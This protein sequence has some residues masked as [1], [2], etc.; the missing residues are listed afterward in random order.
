MPH[1]RAPRSRV[2]EREYARRERGTAPAREHSLVRAKLDEPR[3]HAAQ[4][5]Q[6]V[7][8]DVLAVLEQTG[9]AE[10]HATAVVKVDQIL[11]HPLGQHGR[12]LARVEVFCHVEGGRGGVQ[13]RVVAGG[14][15][16]GHL[17]HRRG[18]LHQRR[19]E[20][21]L[22][23]RRRRTS[24]VRR[25]ADGVRGGGRAASDRRGGLIVVEHEDAGTAGERFLVLLGIP[26][27]LVVPE[28]V[29]RG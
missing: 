15:V 10:P 11:A 12:V 8:R 9:R 29:L 14:V 23:C 13:G 26:R 7:S 27:G 20:A 4:R 19:E 1:V 22:R 28:A 18:G 3:S 17:G 24:A 16:E 6:H 5:G 2:P 21:G 25:A